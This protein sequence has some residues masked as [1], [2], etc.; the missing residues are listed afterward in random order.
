MIERRI[1]FIV[2]GEQDELKF[3]KR[4]IK[5]RNSPHCPTEIE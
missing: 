5:A 2:E 1:L 3:L 4:M